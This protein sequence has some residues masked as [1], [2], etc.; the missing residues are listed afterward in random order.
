MID[1]S[2]YSVT[3]IVA[4]GMGLAFLMSD[5]RSTNN[6]LF[7]GLLVFVALSIELNSRYQRYDSLEAL[8]L[9]MNLSGLPIA[10]SMLF[11]AEWL[12][13]IRQ[14]V[15]A[16][17][18]DTR[19]GDAVLRA[20]QFGSVAFAALSVLLSHTRSEFIMFKIGRPGAFADWRMLA[21]SAPLALSISGVA[22]A[23]LLTLNR[24]P[25]WPEKVRLIAFAGALPFLASGFF[26]RP[27]VA[28]F[29]LATG[30]VVLL[31]G[32]VEYHM[33]QGQRGQFMSRFLAP[34]VADLVNRQGLEQA[35]RDETVEITAVCCDIRGFTA[36]ARKGKP[37]AVIAFLRDYYDAVGE[38]ATEVG[39]TIKDYA[40]DGVLILVGAPLPVA[41]FARRGVRLGQLLI[42]RA[43]PVV[44]RHRKGGEP[45]GVA[46]GIAT[47]EVMVGV[48]GG[49]R[50]EYVAVGSTVNLA[51]RLCQ[52]A[53]AGKILI[54]ER[55]HALVGDAHALRAEEAVDL[56]G[57]A[58]QVA[59]Y[60]LS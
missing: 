30:L 41:D 34:Q 46:V 51:A 55:T 45:L 37:P 16:K 26:L 44:K 15:P 25:D 21:L 12:T 5:W 58:G 56:K 59:H 20:S 50:L 4:A 29:G 49:A 9:W 60:S 43:G 57:F 6:R 48:V 38:A 23:I 32:A 39:A 17:H 52:I 3:A 42:E 47:G 14:T 24:K 7:A 35:I 22:F 27:D 11:A 28:V 18:M 40:G 36:F 1:T 2:A 33:V 10:L 53:R 8:P 31:V 54:D 13:R 19:V